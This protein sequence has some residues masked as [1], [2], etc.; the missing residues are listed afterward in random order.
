MNLSHNF[1]S[2]DSPSDCLLD[3]KGLTLCL[4]LRSRES[5]QLIY[6]IELKLCG[7]LQCRKVGSKSLDKAAHCEPASRPDV[8]EFDNAYYL[9]LLSRAG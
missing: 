2:R 6:R 4:G 7:H 8:L 1:N 3:C 9:L 5:L